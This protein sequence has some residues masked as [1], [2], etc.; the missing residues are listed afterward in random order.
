M[1]AKVFIMIMRNNYDKKITM[2]IHFAFCI[3]RGVINET[4]RDKG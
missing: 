3:N 2:A 1:I 4:T